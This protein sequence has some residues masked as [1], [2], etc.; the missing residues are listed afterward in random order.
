MAGKR[1]RKAYE[2]LD[3]LSVSSVKEAIRIVKERATAKFD[4]T[5]EVAINL[6]LDPRKSDQS[7]RGVTQLPAGTGK[8]LRVAVFAKGPK[9]EEAR[10]AGA[11]LVGDE[12]LAEKIQAGEINFDRCIATPDMMALLGKLAR[13]L[14]PRGLMPNPKLGTV[15]MDVAE[16]VK[17]AKG[18]QV[19]YRAEKA[20]IIHAGIGKASFSSEDIEKNLRSFADAIMKAKPTGIKGSYIKK[21]SLSS[22]M[23]PSVKMEIADLI[24]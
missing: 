8:T 5:I 12:D 2:G 13:V 7:I 9:A 15:T 19:E 22:T 3:S 14:G 10:K 20:G 1:I 16:A 6:N 24:N 4:E 11:D 17:A 21:V 18:G 23:G